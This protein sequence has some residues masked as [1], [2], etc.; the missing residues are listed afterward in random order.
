MDCRAINRPLPTL[1]RWR[2]LP[3]WLSARARGFTQRRFLYDSALMQVDHAIGKI[4]QAL[5]QSG[6][7]DDTIVLVTGDHGSF[8]AENPR[9]KKFPVQVRT[10]Y[11]DIEVPLIMH[12]AKPAPEGHGLIDSMGVTA[13][14]LD[15]LG[16]APDSSFKGAGVYTGGREA[17]ISE[18]CGSD[19]ADLAR[20][21]T[22]RNFRIA[23][24]SCSGSRCKPTQLMPNFSPE[25]YVELVAELLEKNTR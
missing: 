10:H 12:G 16:V 1:V 13:S 19:N 17:V 22:R 7:W 23:Q 21:R 8:Y 25:D 4:F 9:G 18:S 11:E 3:R 15:A 20:R 24:A 6:Q 2:F 14:L 5:R